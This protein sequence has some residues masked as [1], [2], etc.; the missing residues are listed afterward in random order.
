VISVSVDTGAV[1]VSCVVGRNSSNIESTAEDLTLNVP[2]ASITLT[3]ADATRGWVIL[4]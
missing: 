4:T 3:Y 1:A 2:N